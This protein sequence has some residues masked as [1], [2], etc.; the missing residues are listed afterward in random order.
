MVRVRGF[1]VRD[2][3]WDWFGERVIKGR[4]HDGK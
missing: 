2:R 4:I 3:D 1:E